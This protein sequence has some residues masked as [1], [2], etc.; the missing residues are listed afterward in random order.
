MR[1]CRNLCAA[2]L[3]SMSVGLT[4]GCQ[5]KSEAPDAKESKPAV[6]ISQPVE[7]E[8]TNY[9]YFTGRTEAA[10]TKHELATYAAGHIEAEASLKA[11]QARLESFKPNLEFT[12]VTAPLTGR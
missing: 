7:R 12:A 9:L 6:T 2:L 3:F 11:A 4:Q 1:K 8:V 10:I 5:R